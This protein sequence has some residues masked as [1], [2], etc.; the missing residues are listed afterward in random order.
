[1]ELDPSTGSFKLPEGSPESFVTS[2][3]SNRNFSTKNPFR[4]RRG[5]RLKRDAGHAASLGA[6]KKSGKLDESRFSEEEIRS[7][8]R[9]DLPE[10]QWLV[11]KAAV[12]LAYCGSLRLSELKGLNF[13][14][15]EF[16]EFGFQV[17]LRNGHQFLVPFEEGGS[18]LSC[19]A[20]KVRKY[21]RE[22]KCHQ[23]KL[24]GLVIREP[25]GGEDER[26]F[27]ASHVGQVDQGHWERS[28]GNSPTGLAGKIRR[29]E[30]LERG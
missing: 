11:R 19:M 16:S 24:D 13:Q 27:E 12:S 4:Q 23:R 20:T 10:P 18:L 22:V 2:R 14:G 1:M 6:K 25:S 15:F 17:T 26:K 30:L 9:L 29:I 3:L 5:K 21:F 8:L 28:G 7:F